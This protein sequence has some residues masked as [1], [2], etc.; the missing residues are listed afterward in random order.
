MKFLLY[1][2]RRLDYVNKE[3]YVLAAVRAATDSLRA[4][5]PNNIR[6]IFFGA[7]SASPSEITFA[8]SGVYTT[9][10]TKKSNFAFFL[11]KYLYMSAFC[12]TFD[13]YPNGN[14]FESTFAFSCERQVF[15]Q[16]N[17]FMRA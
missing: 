1:F 13:R 8:I 11:P 7:L 2:G 6:W 5:T 15:A 17:I 9:I 10:S 4:L 12:S 3:F 16:N 14:P